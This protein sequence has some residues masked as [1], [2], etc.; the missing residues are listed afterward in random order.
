M[1]D[2]A[3]YIPSHQPKPVLVLGTDDVA[4][5]VG[6][7]LA[8]AAIRTVLVRD[9]EVPVLRRTMSYDDALEAGAA[10]LE[11]IDATA[12]GHPWMGGCPDRIGA[13]P[14]HADGP[15]ADRGRDLCPHAAA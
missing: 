8:N 9:P 5:A 1:Q 4:S 12:T 15:T 2:A 3:Y 7:A 13:G 11:G 6:W 14:R 10:T